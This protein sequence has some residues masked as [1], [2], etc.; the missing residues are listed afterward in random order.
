MKMSIHAHLL[1]REE[2][3]HI[4]TLQS[5]KMHRMHPSSLYFTTEC[6]RLALK[7]QAYNSPSLDNYGP[8]NAA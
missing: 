2:H 7:D 4:H 1:Q 8:T 5:C 6:N 3:P